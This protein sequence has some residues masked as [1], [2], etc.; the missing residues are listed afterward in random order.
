MFSYVS[1]KGKIVL[2]KGKKIT[3]LQK[4]TKN[5]T[6]SWN[7]QSSSCFERKKERFGCEKNELVSFGFF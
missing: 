6:L 7:K 4:K 1:F 5:K 3:F 2:K